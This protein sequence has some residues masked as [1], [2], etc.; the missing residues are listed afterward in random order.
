MDYKTDL[1]K[2]CQITRIS[3]QGRIQVE[4]L[5]LREDR[6]HLYC[7]DKTVSV[8]NCLSSNL[9]QLAVGQLRYRGLIQTADEI[10]AIHVDEKHK[11]IKVRLCPESHTETKASNMEIQASFSAQDIHRLQNDFDERCGLFRRTGSAHSC[12]LADIDGILYYFED[13]A[14]HNAMDKMLGEFF[15]QKMKADG[16]ALFFS[17]RLALDM[18]EKS[19]ATGVKV[20]VSPGAPTLTAVEAAQEYGITL[21]GFVRHDNINIYSNPQRISS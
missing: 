19:I 1:M 17:G 4:D 3:P 11:Q 18:L 5:L 15:L 10:A 6:W 13:V 12:A 7:D 21:L 9:K 20:L 8:H 2:T 14:R 16:K